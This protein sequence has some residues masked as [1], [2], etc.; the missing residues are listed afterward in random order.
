M[1]LENISVIGFDLDN[2][3]YPVTDEMQGRIRGKIYEKLAYGLRISIEDAERLFEDNY[4]GDFEWSFSG[5]RTIKEIARQHE[6]EC[7]KERG[8]LI[9]QQ[10]I[11]QADILDFI[12]PNPGLN[13][14]LERLDGR[15]V[16]DL[17]T[18]TSYDLAYSKLKKIGIDSERFTHIL[19]EGKYGGKST[20]EVFQHW[21]S[22][23]PV[24]DSPRHMYVGDNKKQD[25]DASKRLGIRTCY[26]G[27]EY[28]GADYSIH[29]IL[30]LESLLT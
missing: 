8:S 20:G 24:G 27:G 22:L 5:S 10:S 14:M 7:S 13:E 12:Q 6:K 28:E 17:I 1:T 18:G 11:E 4:N 9:V 23:N 15:F 19:A 16:L 26:V 2:T 29:N 3:L 25:I 21:L 30:E